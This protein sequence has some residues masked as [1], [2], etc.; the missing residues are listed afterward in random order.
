VGS[1]GKPYRTLR[2][3]GFEILIGRGS[4]ENDELT[5]DVADPHDTWL[6]ASG[7]TAGSHVVIKNPDKVEIPKG[8]LEAAAAAAAWYSKAR[9][10]PKV[11]VSYCRVSEVSKPRGAP[12]G[13]VE[14]A[15]WKDIKVAPGIPEGGD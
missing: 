2:V 15:R 6:H 13:M 9:G 10:A 5:F 12:V 3:D 11:P 1:R 4:A 8:V 14:L 7:G